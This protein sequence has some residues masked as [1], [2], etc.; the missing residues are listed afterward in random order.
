M[1]CGPGWESNPLTTKCYMFVDQPLVW[2]NA[3][4]M[5]KSNNGDLVDIETLEEQNYLAGMYINEIIFL[6]YHRHRV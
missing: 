3:Y 5:C 6:A 2:I 4:D 1:K